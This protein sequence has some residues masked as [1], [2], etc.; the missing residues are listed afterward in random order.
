MN[1]QKQQAAQNQ[2]LIGAAIFLL[3]GTAAVSL[4]L[5]TVLGASQSANALMSD[6]LWQRTVAALGGTLFQLEDGRIAAPLCGTLWRSDWAQLSCRVFF[7][8]Y[9][10]DVLLPRPKST[11]P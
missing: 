7:G 6:G 1:Q 2:R 3:L 4:S 9:S 5:Q 11:W 10:A 8:A